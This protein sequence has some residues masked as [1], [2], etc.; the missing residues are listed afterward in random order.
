M[1]STSKPGGLRRV[2]R[3]GG[4]SLLEMLVAIS[5]LALALGALYQAAA[6]ATRNVRIDEKYAYSVELARSLLAEHARVPAAGAAYI[7]AVDI[8]DGVEQRV[9][10]IQ[11]RHRFFA[12]QLRDDGLEAACDPRQLAER[13]S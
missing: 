10:G 5:I 3:A 1:H 6:G 13:A 12:I 11:R 9:L 8:V 7:N 2:T 4:F